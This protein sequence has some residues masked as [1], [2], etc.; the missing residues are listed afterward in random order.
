[1]NKADVLKVAGEPVAWRFKS[2]LG[3]QKV[4]IHHPIFSKNQNPIGWAALYTEAQL[5][6]VAEAVIAAGAEGMRERAAKE[7]SDLEDDYLESEDDL[8]EAASACGSCAAIIR[9][10][11]VT[12]A[13][14]EGKKG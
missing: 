12:Q 2:P 13:N 11:P 1:M 9:A 14:P 5:L 6:A 8:T 10:L 3:F 4:Q 7:C